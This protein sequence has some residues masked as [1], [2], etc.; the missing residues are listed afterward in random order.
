MISKKMTAL[1][2]ATSMLGLWFTMLASNAALV[3]GL[4]LPFKWL[5]NTLLPTLFTAPKISYLQAAGLLGLV[6]LLRNIILG[7]K[8]GAD[9]KI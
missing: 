7:V 6:A 9:F 4:G 5:W 2:V 3:L 1:A 8:V